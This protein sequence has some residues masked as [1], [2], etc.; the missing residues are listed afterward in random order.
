MA[1]RA[2]WSVHH[3]KPVQTILQE[4]VVGVYLA[5]CTT[6]PLFIFCFQNDIKNFFH[7]CNHFFKS[8]DLGDTSCRYFVLSFHIYL[9]DSNLTNSFENTVHINH[10]HN[11]QFQILC[12]G[13]AMCGNCP[14]GFRSHRFIRKYFLHIPHSQFSLDFIS[15]PNALTTPNTF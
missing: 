1:L 12:I 10:N 15:S 7:F 13:F 8:F 11:F 2:T 3:S 9:Y 14:L 6:R 4:G 5:Y